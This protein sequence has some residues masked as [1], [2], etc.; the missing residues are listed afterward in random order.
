[1][2]CIEC[3]NE[4]IRLLNPS[5]DELT[6]QQKAMLQVKYDKHLEVYNAKQ[7]PQKKKDN[8]TFMTKENRQ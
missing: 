8:K 6:P 4:A 5:N 1:M 7:Q 3:K 2:F